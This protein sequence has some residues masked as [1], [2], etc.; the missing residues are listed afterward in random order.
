VKKGWIPLAS[1][2]VL[3]HSSIKRKLSSASSC[4]RI[5]DRRWIFATGLASLGVPCVVPRDEQEPVGDPEA[6]GIKGGMPG[7][8]VASLRPNGAG[9]SRILPVDWTRE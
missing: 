2:L 8:G 3:I 7:G 9:E 6:S 1:L 5:P 4:L